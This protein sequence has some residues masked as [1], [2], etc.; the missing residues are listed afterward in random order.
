M[1]QK[2]RKAAAEI[3]KDFFMSL[4]YLTFTKKFFKNHGFGKKNLYRFEVVPRISNE[5]LH[6][7][8]TCNFSSQ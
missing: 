4:K 1:K 2:Q 6:F 8:Q 5:T 7:H 3:Q